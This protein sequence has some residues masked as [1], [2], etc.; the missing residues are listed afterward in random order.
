MEQSRSNLQR[1]VLDTNLD[2]SFKESGAD[3][4]SPAIS[5]ITKTYSI[6]SQWSDIWSYFDD[7]NSN[8]FLDSPVFRTSTISISGERPLDLN[9]YA[10]SLVSEATKGVDS[11]PQLKLLYSLVTGQR[12]ISIRNVQRDDDSWVLEEDVV[13]MV[14]RTLFERW[15]WQNYM[16]F[17]ELYL[18]VVSTALSLCLIRGLSPWPYKEERLDLYLRLSDLEARYSMQGRS[19]FMIREHIVALYPTVGV[20][21]QYIHRIMQISLEKHQPFDHDTLFRAIVEDD[22]YNNW[23]EKIIV[24][25]EALRT[26]TDIFVSHLISLVYD[27]CPGPQDGLDPLDKHTNRLR[28]IESNVVDG[29]KLSRSNKRDAFVLGIIWAFHTTLSTLYSQESLASLLRFSKRLYQKPVF[30][31]IA[32]S[33]LHSL[34]DPPDFILSDYWPP[35]VRLSRENEND[36]ASDSLSISYNS[37]QR[38][39]HQDNEKIVRSLT[40]V[41]MCPLSNDIADDMITIS[42][43]HIFSRK[44]ISQWVSQRAH[45]PLCRRPGVTIQGPAYWVDDIKRVIK[46]IQSSFTYM[47][48]EKSQAEGLDIVIGIRMT[49]SFTVVGVLHKDWQDILILEANSSSGSFAIPTQV[50]LNGDESPYAWGS[51]VIEGIT[52]PVRYVLCEPYDM[53]M[54]VFFLKKLKQMIFNGLVKVFD[55]AIFRNAKIEYL[56]A[57][58]DN[59]ISSGNNDLL[60]ETDVIPNAF[61]KAGWK[62]SDITF[63]PESKCAAIYTFETNPNKVRNPTTV[64]NVISWDYYDTFYKSY[65]VCAEDQFGLYDCTNDARTSANNLVA[66]RTSVQDEIKRVVCQELK[67][68]GHQYQ[69]WVDPNVQDADI[70][71]IIA[72]VYKNLNSQLRLESIFESIVISKVDPYQRH[73][74]IGSGNDYLQ[75]FL[76]HNM[77]QVFFHSREIEINMH[78][79]CDQS[80]LENSHLKSESIASSASFSEESS[81]ASPP[82]AYKI[83]DDAGITINEE[84]IIKIPSYEIARSMNVA[85]LRSLSNIFDS[86]TKSAEKQLSLIIYG[87]CVDNPVLYYKLGRLLQSIKFSDPKAEKDMLAITGRNKSSIIRFSSALDRKDKS[88][89]RMPSFALHSGDMDD[90]IS[91]QVATEGLWIACKALMAKEL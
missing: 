77:M 90:N 79:I 18:Y 46:D 51:D 59:M 70:N 47:N 89:F 35:L 15:K 43:G 91:S 73:V 14:V 87:S 74:N 23:I 84:G 34:D 20:P 31:S 66:E 7:G 29:T 81:T 3:L 78:N 72:H 33:L 57:L 60:R 10:K 38:Q 45:C 48:L 11:I 82:G 88:V 61:S 63:V 26:P 5:A 75:D 24:I 41:I 6:S 13:C 2:S 39:V 36:D 25:E 64:F 71:E 53:V 56:V 76:G 28:D 68:L 17:D 52:P 16:Q 86:I 27:I 42:C 55:K 62:L 19:L 32:Y 85:A 49:S 8:F 9:L 30:K 4:S 21:G 83:S 50:Y 69:K 37:L 67:K 22:I 65:R 40:D 1:L 12:I 80:L 54:L 58:P 44:M